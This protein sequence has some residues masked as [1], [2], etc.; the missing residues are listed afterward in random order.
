[1]P[2]WFLTSCT[3]SVVAIGSLCRT[4]IYCTAILSNNSFIHFTGEKSSQYDLKNPFP[5]PLLLKKRQ[6]RSGNRFVQKK[7]LYSLQQSKKST[8]NIQQPEIPTLQAVG[9]VGGGGKYRGYQLNFTLPPNQDSRGQLGC[10][11]KL[12]GQ[13]VSTHC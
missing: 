12:I 10:Q 2:S 9:E 7:M 1:M 13:K 8:K 6:R 3:S 5:A 11:T 4:D